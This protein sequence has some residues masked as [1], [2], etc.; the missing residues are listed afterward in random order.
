MD[1]KVIYVGLLL[2]CDDDFLMADIPKFEKQ[3]RNHPELQG[4]QL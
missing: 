1:V 4:L 3:T 2:T